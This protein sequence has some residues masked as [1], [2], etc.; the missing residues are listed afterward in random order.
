MQAAQGTASI[1]TFYSQQ[2]KPTG[3]AALPSRDTSDTPELP[4]EIRPPRG[5]ASASGGSAIAGGAAVGGVKR[6]DPGLGGA[7]REPQPKFGTLRGMPATNP[8]E[9][10]RQPSSTAGSAALSQ[11]H[12][13]HK[14]QPKCIGHLQAETSRADMQNAHKLDSHVEDDLVLQ[15]PYAMHR[16]QQQGGQAAELRQMGSSSCSGACSRDEEA[17]PSEGAGKQPDDRCTVGVAGNSFGSQLLQDKPAAEK[18]QHKSVEGQLDIGT[19]AGPLP[20]SPDVVVARGQLFS[21]P[22][23]GISS[24]E[25]DEPISVMSDS[26]SEGELEISLL[27]PSPAKRYANQTLACK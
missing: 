3:M 12:F 6:G 20:K 24:H 14:L 11:A 7:L 9:D 23:R 17:G 4:R 1:T 13:G 8:A 2:K 27:S 25:D 5:L 19:R 15:S 10:S 16:R 26:H 21:S 22:K 18:C